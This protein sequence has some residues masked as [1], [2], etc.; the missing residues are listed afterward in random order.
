M[1]APVVSVVIPTRNRLSLLAQTLHTVLAQAVE[2]EV[3]VVDEGSSDATPGWLARQGDPRVRTIRHDEPHGLPAARNAGAAQ[4]RGRW[5]AFVDDDDLWLPDKLE[6]Q[7]AT[8]D[9]HGRVWAYG[10][11]LDVTSEPHLLRVVTPGDADDLPWR[12]VVPGGGSNVVVQREALEAAGLFDESLRKVEDWDLWIRLGQLSPPAVTPDPVVA[13]RIHAGNMSRNVEE[14]VASIAVLDRRYRHLRQG[15]GLDWDDVYRWMGAAA[16]R[17]GDR[18]AA[19]R[20]ATA[21]RRAGHQGAMRRYLRA[22]LPLAVRPPVSQPPVHPT[23]LD[24]LRPRAVVP[25]P[26]G[27]EDWLRATLQVTP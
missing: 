2:L 3:I 6:A 25:W 5:V 19:R 18:R 8:A 1:T 4:A 20:L 21:A 15:G 23:L 22:S 13:Y 24:R 9:E 11:A 14:M 12:N 10:G 27:T 7:L 26:P 16:L 17:A